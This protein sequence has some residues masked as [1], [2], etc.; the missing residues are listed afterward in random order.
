[1]YIWLFETIIMYG[2]SCPIKVNYSCVDD[3]NAS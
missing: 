3:I 1:M 2:N